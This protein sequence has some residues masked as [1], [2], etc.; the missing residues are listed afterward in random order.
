[1]QHKHLAAALSLLTVAAHGQDF[2]HYKFDSGCTTEVVNYATG[3]SASGKN[4]ILETTSTVSPWAPGVWGEGLAGGSSVAPTFYNRV[5]TGW[6]PSLSSI[7][8][9]LTIAFFVKLRTPHG[10]STSYFGGNTGGYRLFTNGIAG[11]G[12]YQRTILATGG[13]GLNSTPLQDFYLPATAADI[14]TL[15]ATAWVHVAMV[16]DS[17]AATADW[18]VNGVSV[19]HLTGVTGGALITAAGEV[20][21]GQWSTTNSC[22]DLDEYLIS[23]RAFSA[24]EILALTTAPRAGDGSFGSGI[25]SQCGTTTLTSTGGAPALGNANYGLT[26]GSTAV[27][28]YSLFLGA[29]RC[30]TSG[31]LIPLP[32]DLSVLGPI[33]AGCWLLVD[34]LATISGG[35]AG[36]SVTIPLPIPASTGILGLTLYNQAVVYDAVQ[37]KLGATYGWSLS[38]GS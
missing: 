16:V 13:N 32:L 3:A 10:T 1:M 38:V 33:G 28:S 17:V 29:N 6:D 27:G 5:R 9:D 34:P 18:Y 24:A 35:L 2:I 25:P 37:G 21:V 36:A 15:A 26:I 4:G 20:A 8:G 14:Q 30:T 7:T 12:L 11:R 19:V 31:G 23:K 22:Y